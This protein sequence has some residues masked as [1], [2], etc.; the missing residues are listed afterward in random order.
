MLFPTYCYDIDIEILLFI[1]LA[2]LS[3]LRKVSEYFYNLLKN[4][5]FWR[6]RLLYLFGDIALAYNQSNLMEWSIKLESNFLADR[7][8]LNPKQR[9]IHT[10]AL[11]EYPTP[12]IE[13]YIDKDRCL[14]YA[15]TKAIYQDYFIELFFGQNYGSLEHISVLASALIHG[16]DV[17]KRLP[18]KLPAGLS[19]M[20]FRNNDIYY[21]IHYCSGATALIIKLI[22]NSSLDL[23][24]DYIATAELSSLDLIEIYHITL[25]IK[26]DS[27]IPVLIQRFYSYYN[28]DQINFLLY[29]TNKEYHKPL[30]VCT[31]KYDELYLNYMCVTQYFTP[32]KRITQAD[33]LK[34]HLKIGYLYEVVLPTLVVQE[35]LKLI[36]F[37]LEYL[38]DV[39]GKQELYYGINKANIIGRK[40]LVEYIW[41]FSK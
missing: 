11:Q 17:I 9:C 14:I 4:D 10:L 6:R 38:R 32:A 5:S 26:L 33:I 31:D 21:S 20:I 22:E 18:N 39:G 12:G 3:N 8:Q 37:T 28:E 35:D 2:C 40:D 13:E 41:S 15:L 27:L 25:R 30:I 16:Y 23:A 1:P 19:Q 36:R 34:N 7:L 24:R 29:S